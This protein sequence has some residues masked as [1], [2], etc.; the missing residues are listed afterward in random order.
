MAGITECKEALVGVNELT[1]VLIEVLDDGIQF[2][3]V[4]ALMARLSSDSV[5]R[6]KLDSAL[7]GLKNVPAEISDLDFAEGLELAMLQASYV[8][9]ILD[10]LK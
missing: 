5:L 8:P 1:L 10:K 2:S 7:A 9:K 4:A 6:D 3:D